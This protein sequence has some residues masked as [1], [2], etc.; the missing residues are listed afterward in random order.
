MIDILQFPVEINDM[1][2]LYLPFSEII[3][4][5]PNMAIK[6]YDPEIHTWVWGMKKEHYKHVIPW[7]LS[8][9]KPFCIC[10]TISCFRS[11]DCECE[12]CESYR[13]YKYNYGNRFEEYNDRCCDESCN[14]DCGEGCRANY[15]KCRNDDAPCKS[16]IRHRRRC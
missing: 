15:G 2:C 12:R 6:K 16:R 14:E 8:I 11:H 13:E 4:L 1:I 9:N 5:R 7:F 10:D 3:R